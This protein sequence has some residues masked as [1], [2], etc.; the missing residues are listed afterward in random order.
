MTHVSPLRVI[1][2][3]TPKKAVS[4]ETEYPQR[5]INESAKFCLRCGTKQIRKVDVFG[6][7]DIRFCW[8][9][10][11]KK[12][13]IS[14]HPIWWYLA[15]DWLVSVPNPWHPEKWHRIRESGE[16][17]DCEDRHWEKNY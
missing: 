9:Y 12:P 4:R 2:R 16:C 7:M 8:Q 13:R 6:P 15:L 3:Q 10:I 1:P 5:P 14:N 17:P 11:E